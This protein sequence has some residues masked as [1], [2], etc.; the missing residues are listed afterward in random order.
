MKKI[1]LKVPK[2]K[3]L[4][5]YADND[6]L[7]LGSQIKAYLEED[8]FEFQ[9]ICSTIDENLMFKKYFKEKENE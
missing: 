9:N 7:L 8:W 3:L 6:I 5:W 4:K 1:E 2:K